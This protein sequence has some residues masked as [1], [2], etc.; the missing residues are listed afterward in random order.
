M[1]RKEMVISIIIFIAAVIIFIAFGMYKRRI[2]E[3]RQTFP[4]K[5][6]NVKN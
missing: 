2:P 5:W 1:K 3:P 6:E 4:E